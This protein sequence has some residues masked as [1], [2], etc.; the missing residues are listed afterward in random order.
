MR[1]KHWTKIAGGALIGMVAGLALGLIF[2]G[3]S[4]LAWQNTSFN[5]QKITQS[6]ILDGGNRDVAVLKEILTEMRTSN[7]RLAQIKQSVDQ[8]N[9]SFRSIPAG[10]AKT[11]QLLAIQ[12]NMMKSQAAAN[13]PNP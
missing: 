13:Q 5:R 3:E 11:N 10:I 6:D 7:D 12:I 1:Q 2:G 8:M 9:A 4:A